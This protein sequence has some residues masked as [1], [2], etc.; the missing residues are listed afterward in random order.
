MLATLI[1]TGASYYAFD[2][3]WALAKDTAT[4][5]LAVAWL[6]AKVQWGLGFVLIW[7]T[8]CFVVSLEARRA[9]VARSGLRFDRSLRRR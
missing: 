9:L 8:V 6:A 1:Y 5:D 4:F 3:Q 7:T 2:W